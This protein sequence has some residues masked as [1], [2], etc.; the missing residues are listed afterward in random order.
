MLLFPVEQTFVRCGKGLT[1]V[2]A[3]ID[4]Q[5]IEEQALAAYSKTLPLW[6]R[7]VDD[8]RAND[9][10]LTLWRRAPLWRFS[11]EGLTLETSAPQI[12]HGGN[13]T[14]VNSFDKTKFLFLNFRLTNTTCQNVSQ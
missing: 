14:F 3:E 12:F 4:M 1:V 13:S 2:V 6:L 7:Y 8:V 11:D 9:E 10:G 5:N